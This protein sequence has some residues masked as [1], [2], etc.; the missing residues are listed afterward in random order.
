MQI[1]Y[2]LNKL[3]ISSLCPVSYFYANSSCVGC[4]H[5]LLCRPEENWRLSLGSA[6]VF[7]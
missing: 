2:F 3:L 1:T 6:K 7:T 4:N 5:T